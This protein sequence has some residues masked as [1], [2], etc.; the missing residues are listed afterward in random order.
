MPKQKRSQTKKKEKQSSK[1]GDS[2]SKI[3]KKKK[4]Q[5]TE[6]KEKVYPTPPKNEKEMV[7]VDEAG[8]SF[9]HY[10]RIMVEGCYQLISFCVQVEAVDWDPWWQ[11][12]SCCL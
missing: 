6:K 5:K 3:P 8:S 9:P 4:K 1:S 2:T 10:I 7:G 12:P 11:Q